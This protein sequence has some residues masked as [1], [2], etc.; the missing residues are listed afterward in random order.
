[1]LLEHHTVIGTV[2]GAEKPE[3]QDLK[4]SPTG[5]GSRLIL[6]SLDGNSLEDPARAVQH[7]KDAG[8]LT[9]IDIVIAN[10]GLSPPIGP[11]ENAQVSDI[12]EALTVNTLSPIAL[13]QA[14]LPLLQASERPRWLSVSS[15]AGSVSNVVPFSAHH[16]LAYGMSKAALNFFTLAIHSSQPKLVAYAIHPGFVLCHGPECHDLELI[17]FSLVQTEMGN[18]GA[19]MQGK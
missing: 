13:Y 16:F 12:S 2:R 17:V 3:Y 4:E 1:L 11:L 19:A 10:A 9:K 18:C 6:V 14:T 8:G 7:A 15:A 5:A